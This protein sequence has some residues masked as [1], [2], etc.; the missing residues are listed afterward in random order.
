MKR[1]SQLILLAGLLLS[2]CASEKGIDV[3]SAWMRPTPQGENAAIYF[4]M[5]NHSAAADELTSV[6]SDIADTIEI[7]ETKMNGD[8]M[9]MSQLDSLPIKAFDEVKFSPGGLHLMLMDLKRE[10]KAGE[11]VD[12]IFHFTNFED[13]RVRVAV[14]DTPAP[15]E[16]H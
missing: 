9:E 12:V 5:H 11:E 14:R 10:V 7:H 1:V 2:A 8:V 13:L 6:S 4:V 15:A 16:D 3:H